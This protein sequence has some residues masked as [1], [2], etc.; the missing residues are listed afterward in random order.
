MFKIGYKDMQAITAI[1]YQVLVRGAVAYFKEDPNS[2]KGAGKARKFDLDEGFIVMLMGFMASDFNVKLPEAKFLV[3][4]IEKEMERQGIMPSQIFANPVKVPRLIVRIHLS[5]G[6]GVGPL[7]GRDAYEWR[8][9]EKDPQETVVEIPAFDAPP[10]IIVPTKSIVKG[11][12]GPYEAWWVPEIRFGRKA[13]VPLEIPI[14]DLLSTFGQVVL[15]A[16]SK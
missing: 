7:Q 6:S 2:P 5:K 9:Y 14:S 3:A 15:H 1:D 4:Q 12:E 13:A 8:R 10:G 16:A 11:D